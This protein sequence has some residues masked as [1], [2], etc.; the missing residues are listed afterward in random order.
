MK[1]KILNEGKNLKD[2]FNKDRIALIIFTI[3]FGF[4]AHIIFITGNIATQDSLWLG[5]SYSK[6]GSW[7]ISLGRWGILLVER[8]NNFVM[9][10]SVVTT[11]DI[12]L[13]AISVVFICDIFNFKNRLS[14]FITISVIILSPAIYITFFYIH[15]SLAYCFAFLFSTISIWFLYKFKYKKIGFIVSALSIVATLALYQSYIGVMV[16]ICIM[17]NVISLLRDEKEIKEV[18]LF[19]GKAIL[20]VL[21]GAIVYYSLTSIIFK[22]FNLNLSTYNGADEISIL[23]L[24]KNLKQTI[25]SCYTKFF[26]Y[27]ISDNL[28]YNTNYRRELLWGLLG[29]ISIVVFIIRLSKLK[30]SSS[31]DKCV[32]IILSIIFT[33]SIPIGL[34][35]INVIVGHDCIYALT[36]VQM[37]LF[38][39]FI[40]AIVEELHTI[41]VLYYV[42][43]LVIIMIIITF[44][45]A[46]STSYE[47]MKFTYNQSIMT[48]ERIISR[49][50]SLDEYEKGMPVVFAGIID[51]DNFERTSVLYDFS[52]GFCANNT[53]FHGDYVGQKGTWNRFLEIFF[54]THYPVVSDEWYMIIINNEKFKEMGVFPAQDS[55]QI[56]EGAVVVK[57]KENPATP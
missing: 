22:I 41:N 53:V 17:Y 20:S 21:I 15:T 23:S 10:P 46:G 37:I 49:I 43:I 42:D 39:P 38:V 36:S 4:M 5:F 57:L 9:I 47:V 32:K 34:N 6:P 3:I 16:G 24:I 40:L 11:L 50:E 28:F 56:L 44:F 27:F 52:L 35:I 45:V 26:D 18:F 13:I 55:V 54:G 48:T 8:L 1:E 14:R 2:W 25:P 7:E 31:K 12:I 33:C 29:I 51:D 19:I 30:G